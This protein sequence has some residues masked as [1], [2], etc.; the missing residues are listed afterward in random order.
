MKKSLL[1]LCSL[2]LSHVVFSQNLSPKPQSLSYGNESLSLASGVAIKSGKTPDLASLNALN[3]FLKESTHGVALYVGNYKESHMKSVTKGVKIPPKSGAYYL[4]VSP[5]QIVVM[6]YDARGTYYGIQ[7]LKQLICNNELKELIINDYPDT[8]F[9]GVV[10]GFYGYPWSHEKRLELI[11][12]LG[13]YKMDTYIYGPKDDP[14][15]SS[16]SNPTFSK[17]DVKGGWRLPYPAEEAAKIKE[18]VEASKEHK[19]DFVWAIH[20]GQDI[21][22]NDDDFKNI[23]AKFEMMYEIGVRSFAVFFDDISGEGT[24][25]TKQAALLNRLNKEF[26]NRKS[27]VTPL[28]MCPTEYNKAWA[29]PKADGY[30]PTLGDLLDPS[31]YVMWTGDRVCDDITLESL[32]W[33]NSRTKRPAYIWWNFPVNDY[34]KSAMPQG[35][36][37]GLDTQITATDMIGFTSNPMEHI[38][39]SKIALYGIAD[40]TWNIKAYD[41][42]Q[43]WED[44]IHAV[45]PEASAAYRTFAIHSADLGQ[46]FH[47]FRRDESWETKIIDPTRYTDSAFQALQ[48][49]FEK[50]QSSVPTILKSGIKPGLLEEIIPWLTQFEKLGQRGVQTMHLIKAVERNDAPLAWSSLLQSE[51]NSEQLKAYK[52]HK[53]GSLLLQPFIDSTLL[54]FSRK[55]YEQVSGESLEATASKNLYRIYTNI[56]QIESG[57]AEK[58]GD[59]ILLNPVQEV[60]R[61]GQNQYIGIDLGA[62]TGVKELSIDLGFKNPSVEY[63]QDGLTWSPNKPHS[64]RFIRYI[65]RSNEVVEA[66][67]RRFQ[68]AIDPRGGDLAAVSDKDLSTG[69][70]LIGEVPLSIPMGKNELIIFSEGDGILVD[71]KRVNSFASIPLSSTQHDII[72]SGTGT[73]REILFK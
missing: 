32:Q 33:I 18:L 12:F 47:R 61:I 24:D 23:V 59:M 51:M 67:L 26:I 62:V 20:P 65:N 6:G 35:P 64:A 21:Q 39:A 37:Y 46:N 19:V 70:E 9:R 22:W 13:R 29:S 27:D 8:Q 66:R 3:S 72:L 44:A 2:W 54:R 57:G 16:L 48:Q 11:E 56:P 14:Y 58:S 69:F 40:Y 4:Q 41:F 38:E 42:N 28:I 5:K 1:L 7:T 71:G 15:H 34:A 60:L 73:I 45:V 31:I 68:V 49:E 10:E 36:S 55:L 52:A 63:S 25:A 43:A 50:I 53:S 30:L 17:Y